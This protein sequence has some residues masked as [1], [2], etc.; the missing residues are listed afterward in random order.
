MTPLPYIPELVSYEEGI[1][2]NTPYV[3]PSHGLPPIRACGVPPTLCFPYLTY[4]TVRMIGAAA[5]SLERASL[6]KWQYN[7]RWTRPLP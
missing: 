4:C 6:Q 2:A 3:Y 5:Q 7:Y 1:L